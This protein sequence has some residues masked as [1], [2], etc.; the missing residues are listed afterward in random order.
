MS[1]CWI[2]I[3]ILNF[4]GYNMLLLMIKTFKGSCQIEWMKTDQLLRL[5][6]LSPLLTMP[7]CQHL[8]QAAW[9]NTETRNIKAAIWMGKWAI[10]KYICRPL[11]YSFSYS[12]L[13]VYPRW[14]I[15]YWAC[16]IGGQLFG[17]GGSHSLPVTLSGDPAQ[18]RWRLMNEAAQY[19]ANISHRYTTP[20]SGC[21]DHWAGGG[22]WD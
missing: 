12:V 8:E 22:N 9:C 18:Y 3:H 11:A 13:I 7:L 16:G 1:W 20:L 10:P 4:D 5:I 21:V 15:S 14:A 2:T 19:G 6:L 17:Q